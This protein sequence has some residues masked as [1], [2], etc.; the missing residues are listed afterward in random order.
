MGGWVVAG[1]ARRVGSARASWVR[2]PHGPGRSQRAPKGTGL[3]SAD[4]GV[5]GMCGSVCGVPTLVGSVHRTLWA[6]GARHPPPFLNGKTK[7]LGHSVTCLRSRSQQVHWLTAVAQGPALALG[8]RCAPGPQLTRRLWVS[9]QFYHA[10]HGPGLAMICFLR[11]D[12]LE[13]F[14]VYGTALSMWVSLMGECTPPT[15]APSP[16]HRVRLPP[17]CRLLS[18]SQGRSPD[19]SSLRTPLLTWGSGQCFGYGNTCSL[20]SHLS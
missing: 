9:W 1:G 20:D 4:S 7:P 6:N 13:Y 15:R 18:Q 17:A 16:A 3:A 19:P 10:C 14:S 2:S 8:P 11:L 12:I 5:E